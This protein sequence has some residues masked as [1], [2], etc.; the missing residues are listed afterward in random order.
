MPRST[1]EQ[2]KAV[3]VTREQ[4]AVEIEE[5]DAEEWKIVSAK[6][7]CKPSLIINGR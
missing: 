4:H 6:R 7:R 5:V 3:K 2:E 1:D